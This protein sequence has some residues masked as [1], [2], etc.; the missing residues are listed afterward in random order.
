MGT[1]VFAK[2]KREK[3]TVFLTIFYWNLNETIITAGKK[4]KN[5]ALKALLLLYIRALDFFKKKTTK[6]FKTI[7]FPKWCM[8]GKKMT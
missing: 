5:V 4:G 8:G 1:S 3:K 2:K 7:Y 6:F